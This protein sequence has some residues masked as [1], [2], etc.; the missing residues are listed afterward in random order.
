M[1]SVTG[2]LAQTAGEPW[3]A[4]VP[5][6]SE[7]AL[8]GG[9]SWAAIWSLI[10]VAVLLI[11]LVAWI[12]QRSRGETATLSVRT[13]LRA[14]LWVPIGI[15]SSLL[16]YWALYYG[17]MAEH[18]VMI[19]ASLAF[20]MGLDLLLRVITRDEAV[21]HLATIPLVLSIHLFVWFE[22]MHE[23][24]IFVIVAI[25]LLS[26]VFIQRGGRHIFN[27]SAL[28]IAIIGT[29][30]YLA[31]ESLRYVDISHALNTPPNIF[32][33][34]LLLGLIAQL[35]A[36]IVLVSLGAAIVQYLA[37]A[38]TGGE[39]LIPSVHWAPVTLAIVLLATDPATIPRTGLGRL[40]FGGVYATLMISLSL[41][42][43]AN[44]VSDFFTKVIPIPICNALVPVF[45]RTCERFTEGR[46]YW[47]TPVHNRAHIGVW[48]LVMLGPWFFIGGKANLFE[49]RFHPL[50]GTPKIVATGPVASCET[51]PV[52]CVPFSFVGEARLWIHGEHRHEEDRPVVKEKP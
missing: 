15:Q 38:L 23:G 6:P 7:A 18:A 41:L 34:I 29:G 48:L 24:L 37:I 42:L 43:E 2:L 16:C 1:S 25:A 17:P 49:G 11:A 39:A 46:L 10:A 8:V 20:A 45:D 26:K 22:E 44:G 13:Q 36:P 30:C 3:A 31:P 4:P 19:I 14:D 33:A 21:V 47:L 28:G 50:Y 12:V 32:E 35:R 9:G 27:P 5:R 52:F 40:L 51:N